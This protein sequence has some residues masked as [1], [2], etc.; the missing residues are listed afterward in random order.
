MANIK[1]VAALAGVSVATV[2]RY[3]SSPEKVSKKNI[4]KVATAIEQLNYEPNLLA[5]NFSQSR[6]YSVLVIAPLV[7]HFLLDVIHGIQEVARV[8]G[9]T[10]LLVDAIEPQQAKDKY[11]RMLETRLVE[12]IIDFNAHIKDDKKQSAGLQNIVT[13]CDYNENSATPII[14]VDDVKAAENSVNYLLSLGH[15]NIGCLTG[16]DF[17]HATHHR[18]L[19]Y[20]NALTKAGIPLSDKLIING[21][22]SFASGINAAKEFARMKPRPTAIFS[23]S[24]EMAIGLIQG[25]KAQGLQIPEDISV[26]G[27]DDIEFAKYC[28]PPLT[29]IRQPAKEL[30]ASGMRTLCN[31]I[32]D[33]YDQESILT[34]YFLPTDL[35]VRGSTA[36]LKVK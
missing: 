31:L 22:F 26:T 5:R 29:T 14:A 1:D 11:Y 20:Q 8:K 30:G 33:N 19:G 34:A 12:G 2:S 7:N 28:D 16:L 24:D 13:L 6:S 4:T 9:F 32:E 23:M 10:I 36:A 3:F 18:K 35:I 15:Q 17:V 21:D 25:L 27:F